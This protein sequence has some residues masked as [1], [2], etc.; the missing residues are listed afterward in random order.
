MN[1]G[2]KRTF[3]RSSVPN[4][5]IELFIQYFRDCPDYF[6]T[7]Y[8]REA[9][10]QSGLIA[11]CD[12]FGE[13]LLEPVKSAIRNK[14][15]FSAVRVGDG[16]A[17]I[18]AFGK[19]HGTPCLDRH[20]FE[21][22]IMVQ[23]DAFE[24]SGNSMTV[25]AET[26][27]NAVADADMVGVLG[28]WRWHSREEFGLD[29]AIKCLESDYRGMVGHLRGIDIMLGW[30]RE[31]LLRSKAVAPAHLY[32]SVVRHLQDLI[33]KATTVVCITDR[34]IVVEAMKTLFPDH[35][36]NLIEVGRQES[37]KKSPS[38]LGSVEKS[39]PGDMRGIVCLVGAGVWAEIY[40]G[41]VKDRGGVAIDVGSGFDLMAG[42]KSRPVHHGI[43]SEMVNSFRL[44]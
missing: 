33:E 43:S 26:M 14:K 7:T 22:S 32:F 10:A 1:R 25:L 5:E 18:M 13:R 24:V 8:V 35:E 2:R 34:V 37:L 28:L 29:D 4:A 42:T 39:L 16:E 36:I 30:A 21:E 38:F 9:Y 40:C 12:P 44:L 17:N 11:E 15:P 6:D 20:A 41:M 27:W 31:G 3:P 19:Y 23:K